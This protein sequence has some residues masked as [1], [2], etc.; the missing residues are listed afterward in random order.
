[1]FVDKISAAD[2][3]GLARSVY[4]AFGS[5]EIRQRIQDGNICVNRADGERVYDLMRE[6]IVT[7]GY[8]GGKYLRPWDIDRDLYSRLNR[9][10]AWWGFEFETG[11]KTQAD[12]RAVLE[13]VWDT[14]DNTCF[15]SEG[16]GR[17]AVEVTFAPEEVSKYLNGSAQALKFMDILDRNK[18]RV[19]N[20]ATENVGTHINI[21]HPKLTPKNLTW[22]C[23]CMAR[24]LAAIPISLEGG[25]NSRM[26]MFGRR[27]LYGGFFA[28]RGGDDGESV[29]LEGKLFRTVYTRKE[30]EAYLKVCDALSKCLGLF[31]DRAEHFIAK[32]SQSGSQVSSTINKPSAYLYVNNLYDVAF[33]GA[34]PE[35]MSSPFLGMLDGSRSGNA[36]NGA[37]ASDSPTL[38]ATIA[39]FSNGNKM[40]HHNLHNF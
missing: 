33:N 29:W 8:L 18:G 36:I 11:Y 6:F 28:Q 25:R 21:S 31:L 38:Q 10:E 9:E 20:G 22:A 40:T 5:N 1:M 16:E 24:T 14:L 37:L 12:R 23:Y 26:T 2:N 7:N 30:F 39:A 13:E 35:V 15:D 17:A 32:P 19:Y 4:L 27:N 3:N 34:E